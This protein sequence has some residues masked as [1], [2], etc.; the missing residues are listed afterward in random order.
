MKLCEMSR[1]AFG[2]PYAWQNMIDGGIWVRQKEVTATGYTRYFKQKVWPDLKE[3]Y[4]SM[5]RIIDEKEKQHAEQANTTSG[6][7]IR[8][9]QTTNEPTAPGSTDGDS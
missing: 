8:P 4:R 9:G 5:K 1:K 7:E 2:K 3:I 6:E